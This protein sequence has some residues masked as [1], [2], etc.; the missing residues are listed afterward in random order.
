MNRLPPYVLMEVDARTRARVRR[1]KR[2]GTPEAMREVNRILRRH[3]FKGPKRPRGRSMKARIQKRAKRILRD[4]QKA[5]QEVQA[6]EGIPVHLRQQFVEQA[7]IVAEMV[8][9]AMLLAPK[10]AWANGDVRAVFYTDMGRALRDVCDI[11]W[12]FGR[13]PPSWLGTPGKYIRRLR[14]HT[15]ELLADGYDSVESAEDFDQGETWLA[16]N[17]P[18]YGNWEQ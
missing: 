9:G 8:E 4:I 17:W 12:S 16:A 15:E 13:R 5:I 1:L 14:R 7:S 3:G 18:A 6:H 10:E 2:E 11:L